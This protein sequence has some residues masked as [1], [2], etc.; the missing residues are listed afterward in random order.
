MAIVMSL[1]LV[2]GESLSAKIYFLSFFFIT[3]KPKIYFLDFLLQKA[4]YL[5]A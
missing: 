5:S 4:I 1:I 2:M 3:R